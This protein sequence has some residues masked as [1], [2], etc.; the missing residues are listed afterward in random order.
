M[1]LTLHVRPVARSVMR[2]LLMLLAVSIL[3]SGCGMLG[4]L[5]G[6]KEHVVARPVAA[7][8]DAKPAAARQTPV[9]RPR[10]TTTTATLRY[11]AHSYVYV[12]HVLARHSDAWR[13]ARSTRRR[14]GGPRALL[15]AAGDRDRGRRHRDPCARKEALRAGGRGAG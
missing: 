2:Y 15:P 14:T 10:G 1:A 7:A 12:A 9:K 13:S 6:Q 3:L 4:G 5:G 11:R 8:V